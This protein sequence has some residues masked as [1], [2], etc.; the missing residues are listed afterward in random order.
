MPAAD[1]DHLLL[2]LTL[3]IAVIIAVARLLGAAFRAIHQPQ[4]IGEV[5]AGILLGPSL[6]GWLAPDASAALFPAAAM[7]FLKVLSEIGIVF[8][9]FLIGLE[10]DPGLLRQRG[11]AAVVISATGIVVP[12][13]L[14]A[15]VALALYEAYA[16]PAVSR[17]GFAVFLGAAMSITA[18]PVLARILME[19]DLLRTRLGAL[20]LTCAAVD[21]VA[22]WCLMSVVAALGAAQGG[23]GSV[24]VLVQ[25]AIFAALMIWLMRPLLDRLAASYASRGGLSQNLLATIFVLLMLSALATQW[26]GIHAIFGGFLFGVVM[27]KDGPLARAVADKVEEFATVFLLPL[28]FAYTG[29]RMQVGLLAGPADWATAALLIGV[30]VAGKFGGSLVAARLVGLGWREASALGVLVNTRGLMELIILNIGLDLGLITPTVFA[31]MVLMAIVTTMMAAP[32]LAWLY[33]PERLRAERITEEAANDATS[34]VLVS[35]ALSASGPRLLDLA[36]RLG[37][38]RPAA[39]S[40]RCTSAGRARAACSAAHQRRATRHRSRRSSRMRGPR[41]STSGRSSSRAGSPPTRSARWRG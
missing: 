38:R 7:P 33:P 4:V 10:L 2:V 30:A 19:R 18:F 41:R 35:V 16:G 26:I 6:F 36:V 27:P 1:L 17:V 20:A 37:A 14:G 3:E 22:G 11:R 31:M 28:Y 39:G 25:V 34:R 32:V 8:F 24:G 29:L 15:A 5:V 13:T 12:F 21:D 40:M 23:L 9:M